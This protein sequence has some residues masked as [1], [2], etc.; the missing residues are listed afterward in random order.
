[1]D[2]RL[3]PTEAALQRDLDAWLLANFDFARLLQRLR[4][5][6]SRDPEI[7]SAL[8]SSGWI[9]R[10]LPRRDDIQQSVIDAAI[11]AE[12]FGRAMVV[13]PFF[14]SGFVA[15][16][17]LLEVAPVAEGD[18]LLAAIAEDRARFAC[19]LY[20]PE[21]RHRLDHVATTAAQIGEAW[22]LSGRK[23]MVLDGL[24]A[25]HLL[26]TARGS[27]G[28]G[29]F[30]VRSGAEGLHRQGFHTADDFSAADI[31][32]IDT[33]AELLAMGD[34]VPGAIER[35]VDRAIVTLGADVV[36]AASAALDETARYAGERKQFKRTI[37]SFQV[38]S[39]RLARMFV[40]LEVLRGGLNHALSVADGSAGERA[41]A[42]AGLKHLIGESG[43]YVANQG[44]QLHGGVG[45]VHEFKVSHCFKRILVGDTLFG[46][47]DHHLDRYAGMLA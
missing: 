20:E 28:V 23:G 41:M 34:D 21:G 8:V 5:T 13:E 18:T 24:D 27:Q 30:L 14:R 19:A 44:V 17:L 39:H 26:V 43:R 32:L 36:G 35:A 1:M 2:L 15:A 12:S 37:S 4:T 42:A 47:G 9:A 45:T 10:A 6:A 33:P 25:D 40:E 16:N 3:S 11:I 7:W 31:R 46:N 38:V 29:L 22:R